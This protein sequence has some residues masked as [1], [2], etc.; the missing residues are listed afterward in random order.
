MASMLP[1]GVTLNAN[2]TLSGTPTS[3]GTLN[4]NLIAT[5]ALGDTGLWG[6]SLVITPAKNRFRSPVT[7]L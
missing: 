2:G 3:A 6:Y 7:P 1:A 5:D 4:F